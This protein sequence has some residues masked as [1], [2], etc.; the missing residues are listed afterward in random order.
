MESGEQKA[1][2][3]IVRL[4]NR[5]TQALEFMWDSM[6]YIV[7]ANG[8]KSFPRHIAMKGIEK[9]KILEDFATGEVLKSMFGL[10]EEGSKYPTDKL[11][12]DPAEVAARDKSGAP[13]KVMINGQKA[14]M[15]LLDLKNL[16][17][18]AK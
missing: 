14:T 15:Q 3:D 16:E 10:D 2:S 5:T 1:F 8:A 11:D 4:V 13:T 18:G 6:V 7:P 12:V 9:H 17:V